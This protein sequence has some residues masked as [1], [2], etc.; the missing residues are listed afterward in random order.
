VVYALE[1]LGPLRSVIGVGL[2][3][4]EL[5]YALDEHRPLGSVI[6]VRL[7][8]EC[9]ESGTPGG[10][11]YALCIVDPRSLGPAAICIALAVIGLYIVV[12]GGGRLAS[13]E[14]FSFVHPVGCSGTAGGPKCG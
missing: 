9:C 14:C 4:H 8:S 10:Y 6:V 3:G 11:H 1:E 12:L 13:V 2:G 7:T 5:S